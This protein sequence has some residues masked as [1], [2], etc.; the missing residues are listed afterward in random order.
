MTQMR[1]ARL[2]AR[3]DHA[4]RYLFLTIAAFAISVAATRWYLDLTGYPKIGGGG[5]HVAHML[6]GGLLLLVASLL[7]LVFVGRRVLLL[8]ALLAGVGV[9]LFIDEVGKFITESNDY[10]FAPAAP[11][12]YGAL[13]LLVLVWLLVRRSRIETEHDAMQA[14]V[15]AIR[16]GLDGHLTAAERDRVIERLERARATA[17]PIVAGL[18]GQQATLLSSPEMTALLTAPGR[19]SRGEATALLERALPMRLERMLIVVGLLAMAL[20]AVLASVLLL[21]IAWTEGPLR[22]TAPS[23]PVEFPEDP[24]WTIL[25]LVI[26]VVVGVASGV[27][28]GLVLGHRERAGLRV[29]IAAVLLSLVAG[30]LLTFYVAQFGA[31]TSTV[32]HLALLVL[33]L[34]H[35]RR[36]DAAAV[37]AVEPSGMHP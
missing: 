22:M 14:A 19:L 33:L 35:A 32:L 20:L 28:A 11:L 10:F 29:A 13:L 37:A 2:G 12:I 8:T 27:A 16:D 23:G 36:L 7:P 24:V 34:D 25:L 17:D 31:V 3:R 1:T 4:E 5:L 6:W 18:A 15:D 26:G 21:A 30:G 9:G